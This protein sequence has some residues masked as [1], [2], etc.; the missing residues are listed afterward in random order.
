MKERKRERERERERIR[1]REEGPRA[2]PSP[3]QPH[4]RRRGRM[5]GPALLAW[6]RSCGMPIVNHREGDPLTRDVGTRL[7]KEKCLRRV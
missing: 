1:A 4:Y 7:P 2:Q 6:A 3:Q 5:L